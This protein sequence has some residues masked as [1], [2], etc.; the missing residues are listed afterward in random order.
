M[1]LLASNHTRRQGPPAVTRLAVFRRSASSRF[2][3]PP[4]PKICDC[5]NHLPPPSCQLSFSSRRLHSGVSFLVLL[6]P[7]LRQ[8]HCTTKRRFQHFIPAIPIIA[9]CISCKRTT[10]FRRDVLSTCGVRGVCAQRR[11]SA[12]FASR[13]PARGTDKERR[14]LRASCHVPACKHFISMISIWR[15]MLIKQ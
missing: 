5:T 11:L 1:C 2:K 9:K 14:T 15:F 7:S 6:L 4:P 12:C 10:H 8:C 13:W 3:L